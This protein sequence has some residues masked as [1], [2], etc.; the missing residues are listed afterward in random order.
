MKGGKKEPGSRT[1][2]RGEGRVRG[3]YFGEGCSPVRKG[4]A[5]N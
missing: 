5:F 4:E 1:T 2:T 3:V